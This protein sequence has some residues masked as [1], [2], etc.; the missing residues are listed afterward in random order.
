MRDCHS[1]AICGD[2]QEWKGRVLASRVLHDIQGMLHLHHGSGPAHPQF[3]NVRLASKNFST[4]ANSAVSS[5][6]SLEMTPTAGGAGTTTAGVSPE[7]ADQM[8][9]EELKERQESMEMKVLQIWHV[10]S[11]YEESSAALI[12]EML[13]AVNARD[14][15][16][17]V[18]LAE[19]FILHVEA[20]FAVI[21]DLE[22][23]FL[24]AGIKGE[25][26]LAHVNW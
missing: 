26:L 2:E 16:N 19:R 20:L 11:G 9:P 6:I 22:A 10:L 7:K 17:I 13:K 18:L 5:A 15:V 24:L 4:P 21:D 14:L 23:Q 3:W 1:Q 8:T 25:L 12:G